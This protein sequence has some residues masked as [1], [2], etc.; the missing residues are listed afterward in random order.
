MR[1]FILIVVA[2]IFIFADSITF[3]SGEV[4][5]H[6]VMSGDNEIDPKSSVITSHLIIKDNKISTLKGTI[7]ISLL[8]LKSDNI[9]RDEHMHEVINVKKYNKTV[10]TIKYVLLNSEGNYNVYGNLNLHGVT[11]PLDFSAKITTNNNILTFK[12]KTAFNMSDFNITPPKLMFLTV[13]DF[14]EITIDTK[15]NILFSQ[16]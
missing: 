7:D 16:L 11:K 6:T 4:I 8:D 12:A 15:F 3:K 14:L 10:Y 13:R 1:Y 9:G 2:T 5:V